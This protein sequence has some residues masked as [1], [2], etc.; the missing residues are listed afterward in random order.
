MT[1]L[2][3]IISIPL[4]GRIL[5][6]SELGINDNVRLSKSMTR[7]QIIYANSNVCK[8]VFPND[9]V[10]PSIQVC[11]YLEEKVEF[12]LFFQIDRGKTTKR[13]KELNKFCPPNRGNDL[14]FAS[15]SILLLW[16]VYCTMYIPAV[17]TANS[18]KII[19]YWT[20]YI[21]EKRWSSAL[22]SLIALINIEEF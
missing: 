11:I 9:P 7:W 6:L 3:S 20:I 17:G 13:G 16:Q 4:K 8:I 1:W 12:I 5:F 19:R 15:L 22:L 14:C 2:C 21:S 18:Y 10:T